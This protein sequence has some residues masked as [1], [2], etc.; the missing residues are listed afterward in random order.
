MARSFSCPAAFAQH[1]VVGAV[2]V[3]ACVARPLL[4]SAEQPFV[5]DAPQSVYPLSCW[6]LAGSLPLWGFDG[7][8]P[9]E[10]CLEVFG[11]QVLLFL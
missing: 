8:C 6:W 7:Q 4:F 2:H 5:V 9:H 11:G 10:W 3:P 1:C